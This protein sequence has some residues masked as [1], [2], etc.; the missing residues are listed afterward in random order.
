MTTAGFVALSPR[1]WDKLHDD[2][3]LNPSYKQHSNPDSCGA[4]FTDGPNVAA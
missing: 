4:S 1:Q 2:H 3:D